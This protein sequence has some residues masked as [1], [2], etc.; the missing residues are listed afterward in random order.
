MIDLLRWCC[1]A[2]LP[3]LLTALPVSARADDPPA[4][5]S[6]PSGTAAA[7]SNPAPEIA[8]TQPV[9]LV[10]VAPADVSQAPATAAGTSKPHLDLSGFIAAQIT[11]DSNDT[12]TQNHLI[13]VAGQGNTG[14]L[15][16]A[17][18]A[19]RLN[20]V[21]QMHAGGFA[22]QGRA[23]AD[24]QSSIYFRI[25]HA[26]ASISKRGTTLLLGQTDTLIGNQV[27]P[28]NFN[29][30]WLFT[31]GNAYDRLLQLRVSHDTGRLLVAAA[32]LPNLY[33]ATDVIPHAQARVLVRFAEGRGLIGAAG[34]FGYS[35]RVK[36]P[37]DANQELSGV[38]S[39]LASVDAG[40]PL[41]PVVISAQV[42][43][44]AGAAHGTG[45]NG[46]GNALFVV[47]ASGA[48]VSVPSVGGFLDLF[49]KAGNR[50]S[51]GALGGASII[52][53]TAPG[54]VSV[55][56]SSN[57]TA[58]VYASFA[59]RPSWVFAFEAQG[60]RT[61]RTTDPATP[62]MYTALYDGRLLFGQR[63]SF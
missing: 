55:P 21:G 2:P 6:A 14:R 27:G 31:Q 54:G 52:T 41:G 34:H 62:N 47:D 16:W 56:V 19:S 29:N 13:S 44:G 1:S 50:L 23:E 38:V 58:A 8:S 20:L 5:P 43:V 37:A 60:A 35:N 36:N 15:G 57:V 22:L 63:Y 12:V 40:I 28:N 53:N 33:G 7:V 32:L 3:L 17:F 39:Y 4:V 61:E 45:G 46:I 49:L 9:P 18:D 42:W 24:M 59:L 25:R 51:L 26:Y 10:V 30:D 11:F 48:A